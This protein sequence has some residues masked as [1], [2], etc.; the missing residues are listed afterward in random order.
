[1]FFSTASNSLPTCS[2]VIEQNT[3]NTLYLIKTHVVYFYKSN[4]VLCFY[5]DISLGI[6]FF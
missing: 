3:L 5:P 4:A 1:M 6:I 2:Q